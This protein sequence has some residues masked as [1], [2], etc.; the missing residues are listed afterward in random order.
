VR[1]MLFNKYKK[2][3]RELASC[4]NILTEKHISLIKE[5]V[6]EIQFSEVESR[7]LNICLSIL[8]LTSLFWW[9]NHSKDIIGINQLENIIDNTLDSF[10]DKFIKDKTRIRVGD[11]IVNHEELSLLSREWSEKD[12]VAEDSTTTIGTLVPAI[13]NIRGSQYNAAFTER[14]KI[15]FGGKQGS[16]DP[17]S[18]LF[19]RHFAGDEW[20]HLDLALHLAIVLSST[21]DA[22]SS[23][24]SDM[25]ATYRL[26]DT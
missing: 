24:V 5:F 13:Y 6:H 1:E 18:K 12:I 26:G 4:V 25:I 11:Y 16:V 10:M 7:R 8:N 14:L 15:A 17:V 20:K 22:I 23:V 3:G 9:L 21:A 19:V 2:I